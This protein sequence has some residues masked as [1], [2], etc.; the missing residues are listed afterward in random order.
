MS[1]ARIIGDEKR[2]SAN[3]AELRRLLDLNRRLQSSVQNKILSYE[4]DLSQCYLLLQMIRLEASHDALYDWSSR[5]RRYK[6]ELYIFREPFV[7]SSTS[8]NI[9]TASLAEED[10]ISATM[11]IFPP[12]AAN[13]QFWTLGST[14]MLKKLVEQSPPQL[15]DQD[16]FHWDRIAH[17]INT[18]RDKKGCRCS[19]MECCLRYYNVLLVSQDMFTVQEDT[20][21]ASNVTFDASSMRYI[22]LHPDGWEGIAREMSTPRSAFQCVQ[23]FVCHLLGTKV[24]SQRQICAMNFSWYKAVEK[25]VVAKMELVGADP[26]RIATLINADLERDV[27]LISVWQVKKIL[28]CRR[29]RCGVDDDSWT[30]PI[31]W[32][33]LLRERYSLS[34]RMCAVF[35]VALRGAS[36]SHISIVEQLQRCDQKLSEIENSL[37]VTKDMAPG[38]HSTSKAFHSLVHHTSSL[39]RHKEKFPIGL[40]C[41]VLGVSQG[42]F[43]DVVVQAK[44]KRPRAPWDS[45]AHEEFGFREMGWACQLVYSSVNQKAQAPCAPDSIFVSLRRPMFK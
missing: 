27:S 19:A 28:S 18:R 31:E 20:I 13:H 40:C 32:R 22:V 2:N 44:R 5:K 25:A 43:T 6:C 9:H 26:G 16:L 45:F 41:E 8:D 36:P 14:L 42:E 15:L 35:C 33:V 24:G 23:R 38:K 39:I 1:T 37:V 3:I 17:V 11:S 7:G 4:R 34:L 29:L 21:I 30:Q 12:P 10:D